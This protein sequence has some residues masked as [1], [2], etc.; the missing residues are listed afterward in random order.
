MGA[1][2]TILGSL[3]G[4]SGFFISIWM[5]FTIQQANL[6]F[7]LFPLLGIFGGI[8]LGQLN[9]RQAKRQE[10]YK[11]E[12]ISMA[13]LA[14]FFIIAIA[15]YVIFFGADTVSEKVAAKGSDASL[16]T[17]SVVAIGAALGGILLELG[18]GLVH[19]NWIAE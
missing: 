11:N 18:W 4:A 3:L 6:L 5:A 15:L 10:K 17:V 12:Y 19:A 16:F 14:F 7:L 13:A 2:G 9:T 8:G 1:F